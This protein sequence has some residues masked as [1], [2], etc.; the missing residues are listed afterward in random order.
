MLAERKHRF[1]PNPVECIGKADR[2]CCFPFTSRRRVDRGD[3]DKFTCRYLLVWCRNVELCLVMAV[4]FDVLSIDPQF[5]GD[6]RDG[7]QAGRIRNF[8]VSLHR[9]F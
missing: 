8:D 3:K 2:R 6:F 7:T 1:A 4:R 5:S 9:A